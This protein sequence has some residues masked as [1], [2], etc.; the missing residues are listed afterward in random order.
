VR[1]AVVTPLFPVPADSG[2]RIRILH[3]IRMLGRAFEVAVLSLESGDAAT[4]SRELQVPVTICPLDGPGGKGP[5]RV[6]PATRDAIWR[7]A[8]G[9]RAEVIHCEKTFAAAAAGLPQTP[10]PLP[11]I[12]DEAC[13]HHVSYRREAALAPT[14]SARARAWLRWWRLRRFEQRIAPLAHTVV[15]VSEDEAVVIR[16]LA[17]NARVIVA[18]NGV[19]IHTMRP[20]PAG[21]ALLFVGLMSYAPNRDAV[22]YFISDIL[23]LLENLPTPPDFLVVGRDPGPDLQA[24]ARRNSRVHLLGFVPDLAPIYARTAVFVNAMRGGGG[25][26]LK[27]LEAMAAGK[28]IVSTSVGVEGLHVTPGR[29]VL[30]A[31]TPASF[32]QAVWELLAN[33]ERAINLGRAARTLVEVR[34]RWQTCLAP[35]LA[36]YHEFTPATGMKALR[37]RG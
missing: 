21:D 4:A 23:P 12:L 36:A 33:R 25:T 27:V 35:L 16:R 29:D 37:S 26:R 30:V 14:A 18:P 31:D 24:L 28:A 6:L 10:P 11:T 2:S 32:A 3:I 1:I 22:R 13:V 7:F 5:F 17:R 15:A 8:E 20:T 34:Y 19:D 9:W